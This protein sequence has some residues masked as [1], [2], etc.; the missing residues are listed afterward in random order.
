MPEN[1]VGCSSQSTRLIIEMNRRLVSVVIATRNEEKHVLQCI[2]SLLH[3]NFGSIEII[4]VDHHSNDQ[5]V[6]VAERAGAC[7][8]NL[9]N[10][11]EVATIENFR[12]AQ[13]NVGVAKSRGDVIFF[14][15]ADMTFDPDLIADGV[16]LLENFDA[17]YIP[18]IVCGRGWFGAIRRFER[19]FYNATVIDAVRIV[20]REWFL[21]IN[22]F[23]ARNIPFGTDDWD[24]TKSLKLSG[25]RL[26]VSKARLYHHEED[27]N[28]KS[29]IWKK[30][31]YSRTF[32]GY[33]RKWGSE[34]AD[35]RKQF[36]AV[37][38]GWT[39]FVERGKWLRFL[40]HPLLALSLCGIK[41]MIG[42]ACLPLIRRC[43]FRNRPS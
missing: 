3:Q 14:P 24:F 2:D 10:E 21:K 4:V 37:Y 30:V 13:I 39:V 28:L 6:S 11:T 25:A 19:T 32:E 9:Q 8:L 34:D 26:G 5:T 22:G 43:L 17:L 20:K 16:R 36:G 40:S 1:E 7:V 15:D 38:R 12:G 41:L 31:N 27:L 42:V 18:E 29:Y 35:V 23:D 33:I